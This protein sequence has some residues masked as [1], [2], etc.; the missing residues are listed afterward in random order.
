M[1]QIE[2]LLISASTE[3]AFLQSLAAQEIPDYA[4]VFIEDT[5]KIYAKGV[6]YPCSYS[7]EELDA[8][9]EECNENIETIIN[10]LRGSNDGLAS[11]D[12]TGKVP[13]SQ[14][15]SYV[16]DVL[17]YNN[18]SEF[19][20]TGES[21]KIYIAKDTNI[22][23][24]W[25]GS[26]YVE[27]GQSLALGETSSTAY[28]GN[29]GKQNADN[30][31]SLQTKTTNID[32]YTVNGKKI[33]TN[34]TISKS[35]VGLG[36]VDNTSDI[37]KPIS[38]AT[39]AA[40][41]Q[42]Q[43]TLVSGTNIK[44]INNQSLLGSGNITIQGGIS[45]IATAT[46]EDVGGI[47]IG[48]AENGKNYPVELDGED[49]AYVN[50]P[51]TDNN[52]TYNIAT[53]TTAGLVK[54]YSVIA[55]PTMNP[56]TS[57][58]GKYYHVQMVSDGNMLVNVPWQNTTYNTSTTSTDGLMSKE[59]KTKLDQLSVIEQAT[60]ST[61]GLVK[62]GGSVFSDS[63]YNWRPVELNDSGQM[64]VKDPIPNYKLNCVAYADQS[65]S[66]TT[67]NITLT[68]LNCLDGISSNIQTQLNNKQPTI[69]GGASTITT[70]NLTA[71]RV[72]VSNSAGKVT[73]S[74]TASN[75]LSNLS[76]INIDN[77]LYGQITNSTNTWTNICNTTS[78]QASVLKASRITAGA[79]PTMLGNSTYL[80]DG[81]AV[82][83]GGN[84]TKGAVSISY[85][86]PYVSFTGGNATSSWNMAITGK[87]NTTYNLDNLSYLD[88]V[89]DNVQ[90][91]I[92][93][94]VTWL[95]ARNWKVGSGSVVPEIDSET[96]L[97]IDSDVQKTD[98]S[99]SFVD[100]SLI[101]SNANCIL[102]FHTTA[103]DYYHQ[104]LLNSNGKLYS[105]QFLNKKI[106]STT[107]W[108]SIPYCETTQ[109]WTAA[110]TFDSACTFNTACTWN[111][112]QD[113]T[114]G[115]GNSGSDMRFKSEIE[116]IDSTLNDINKLHVIKY[117]W[118]HPDEQQLKYTF[119]VNADEL[120]SLG[121]IYSTMVH[122]RSDDY[123]T[124]WVEYDRFGVLA[125][126]GLQ[127]LNKKL[128]DKCAK[129]EKIISTLANKLDINIENL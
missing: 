9:F 13:A 120:L 24:R 10:S 12:S 75:N 53:T 39:Q 48:Y 7:K 125:I 88:G 100:P 3:E 37:N 8:K 85:M 2:K 101:A 65:Y 111:A 26:T 129:Y 128:E 107:H 67:S 46:S 54:P 86:Q 72:L 69:T 96:G 82:I 20:G 55:R 77:N 123:N 17:E 70:N 104:V 38:T 11:L 32:N 6:Y 36:N 105:R 50:V 66:L 52:T 25:S 15:P 28:A 58:A 93:K 79:V 91:Q 59:D 102:T 95:R 121:G 5:K 43:N 124:K 61:L 71:N 19:P 57:T 81:S 29:K 116:N 87:T 118:D 4:I 127:E 126:K 42:K 33:S 84:D 68:E 94:Q 44:T 64:Y 41:N 89:T 80:A 22:T 113:F 90:N 23:Y 74:T 114:S 27:I 103:G 51:W 106:D 60:S 49:K 35:D 117:V 108:R 30:I 83:F 21:G 115:A 110:Q 31:A 16:D 18:R 56:V 92:S 47:K 34:P 97:C 73:V 119:G 63:D 122:T 40:L 78:N 112:Y 45:S 99:E 109:T 98:L 14:L 76:K 62:L 1:A